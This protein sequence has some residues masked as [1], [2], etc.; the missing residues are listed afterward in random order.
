M[1]R[2]SGA[3]EEALPRE[4]PTLSLSAGS[5]T[6]AAVPGE[7]DDGAP[8]GE[9]KGEV[10]GEGAS[11]V[12]EEENVE[13][14]VEVAEGSKEEEKN[15]GEDEEA[16]KA[17]EENAEAVSEGVGGTKGVLKEKEEAAVV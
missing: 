1:R 7:N 2:R 8:K 11:L 9:E 4:K 15:E 14:K 3:E 16:V 10:A 5:A 17:E 12:G 6:V 13:V